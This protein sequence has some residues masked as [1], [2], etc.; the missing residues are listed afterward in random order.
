MGWREFVGDAG[1]IVGLNHYGAS[2]A[3][4]VLYEKFGLTEEAV[5][6]AARESIGPRVRHRRPGRSGA[7]TGDSPTPP[8][9]ADR[10]RRTRSLETSERHRHGTERESGRA[11]RR[12]GLRLARRPVPRPHPQ[13]EPAVARRRVL[14]RR[15]DHQPDHLR[16]RDQRLGL[17]RRPA[18]RPRRPRRSTS[19]RPCAPSPPPTSGTPAT[20]SGRSHDRQPG[21]GRVSLEVAPGLAHDT[22]ATAAEAAHLWWLV[23]RPNLYIKIPATEAGLPAITETIAKGISVNVTLIFGL[24]RYRGGHGRLPGRPGEAAGQGGSLEGIGVGGLVLRL[25]GRHRDRQAAGQAGADPRSRAR[26][27]SPT[28]S[29]PTRPTR[30]SYL[31]PVARARGEGRRAAAAAVGLDRRQEPEY[32]DTMYISELIAPGTV[33]TMPEKTMKAYADHGT[34]GTPVQK[35]Y[36][37][38]A[39]VMQAIADA[40]V[41]LDDVFR[42]LEVEA[43]QKFVDAWD[44]LTAS[45]GSELEKQA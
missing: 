22:D 11:V 27:A 35:S 32:S 9:T 40:G 38:A 5:V 39:G 34:P 19:R 3:Y 28:P 45:V 8:A 37:E 14:R 31:R 1:R 6:A 33:N 17:L 4:T 44:E 41:D 13:R 20:C 2:A 30:R 10:S 24:E 29:W 18:A 36:D 16:R 23:D 43:V 42:V 26:P 25:P 7:A 21:D 15:G 12:G